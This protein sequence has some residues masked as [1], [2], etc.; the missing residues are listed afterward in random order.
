MLQCII[1]K[2]GQASKID[3]TQ[4]SILHKGLIK[5][6]KTNGITPMK[7]HVEATQPKVRAQRK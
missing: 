7:T 3:L 4:R 6:N 1:C 2:F 5:Y